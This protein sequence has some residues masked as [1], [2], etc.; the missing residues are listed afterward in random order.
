MRYTS[1]QVG[2]TSSF[3]ELWARIGFGLSFLSGGGDGGG[4]RSSRN[5]RKLQNFKGK[6]VVSVHRVNSD[7]EHGFFLGE[8]LTRYA[9]SVGK[10]ERRE[11]GTDSSDRQE[12][13][14]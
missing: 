8:G 1:E 9:N 12:V 7:E 3:A 13:K 4:I 5:S 6:R 14:D 11:M 10:T 2:Y